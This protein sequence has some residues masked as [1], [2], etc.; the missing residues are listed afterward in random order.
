M[1]CRWYLTSIWCNDTL[2]HYNLQNTKL[3]LGWSS[4]WS[5]AIKCFV[6][7][8]GGKDTCSQFEQFWEDQRVA[9]LG[10][11]L[12]QWLNKYQDGWHHETVLNMVKTLCRSW[13]KNRTHTQYSLLF[14]IFYFLSFAVSFLPF[15]IWFWFPKP[16]GGG[17][18]SGGIPNRL[19]QQQ[20]KD[21]FIFYPL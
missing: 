8:V 17:P 1:L 3:A 11:A 18:C 7:Q 6:V 21:K 9:E 15:H 20:D 14:I 10:L 19:G 5:L 16:K 12:I 4:D 13:K 2:C